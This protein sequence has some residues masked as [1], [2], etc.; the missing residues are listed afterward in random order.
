M[1]KLEA[2]DLWTKP[3]SRL[4]KYIEDTWLPE[5]ELWAACHRNAFHGGINTNNYVESGNRVVKGIIGG[6]GDGRIDSLMRVI[7]SKVLPFY[8]KKYIMENLTSVRCAVQ[9]FVV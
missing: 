5:V 8:D 7:C 2:S 9:S 4:K 1:K 3:G 6:R